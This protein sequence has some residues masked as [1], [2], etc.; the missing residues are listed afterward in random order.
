MEGSF[1]DVISLPFSQLGSATTESYVQPSVRC[2]LYIVAEA[3]PRI[4]LP[5]LIFD[6][7]LGDR[8]QPTS[9]ALPVRPR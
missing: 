9:P 8:D 3:V 2:G 4:Q 1:S 6:I 5:H 7:W